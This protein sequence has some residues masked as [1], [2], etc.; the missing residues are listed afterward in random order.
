MDKRSAKGEYFAITMKEIHEQVK[1]SL[2]QSVD[3]YKLRVDVKRRDVQFKVGDLVMAYLRKERLPKGQPSKLLM[4]KI[5][6]L[7]VVHKFGNNAYE[8]E[9]P[10]DLGIYPIFNVRDLTAFKGSLTNAT[11]ESSLEEEDVEWMKDLLLR[12]SLDLECILDSKEAK[13]EGKSEAFAVFTH[14]QVPNQPDQQSGDNSKTKGTPQLRVSL[15]KRGKLLHPR[16]EV[17]ALLGPG[18]GGWKA[19]LDDAKGIPPHLLK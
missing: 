14:S 6:P 10:A 18:S 19:G 17:Q 16:A 4:K 7:W 3:K 1:A 2:Q 8:V 9:L 15:A 11:P 12:N 13:E 5:G